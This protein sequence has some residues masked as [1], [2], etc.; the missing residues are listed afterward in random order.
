MAQQPVEMI[1]VRQ[2]AGYLYVPVLVFEETG[3]IDPKEV[4][5]LI[6]LSDDAAAGH[7]ESERPVHSALLHRRPVHAR[8]WLLRRSD[9]VRLQVEITAFPVIDQ[10]DRLLG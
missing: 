5:R 3:R 6:E 9:R 10:D 2:L 8:R 4:D 7:E 1:L